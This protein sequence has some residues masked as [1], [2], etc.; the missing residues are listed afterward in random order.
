MEYISAKTIVSGYR[1]QNPWFGINYNLNIYRGC[2]HG[3]IYCDSRSECYRVD[4]FD[5]VR[6]KKDALAIIEKELGGKRRKGVVGTGAMSDPY[7]PFEEELELTRGALA[8]I[9]AYGFGASVCTK[10]IW[11]RGILIFFD[12]K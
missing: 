1:E 4:D 12:Y 5:C 11:L 2:C 7:N 3:C 9:N 6:A 8:L 10:A